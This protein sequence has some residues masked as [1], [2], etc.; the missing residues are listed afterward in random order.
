MYRQTV[1][2][3]LYWN[4]APLPQTKLTSH[5]EPDD[6]ISDWCQLTVTAQLHQTWR[7]DTSWPPTDC[8][9]LLQPHQAPV[10]VDRQWRILIVHTAG[11]VSHEPRKWFALKNQVIYVK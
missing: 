5:I 11:Y 2:S 9:H 8:S 4:Y 6:L 10:T 3:T 7:L 1:I